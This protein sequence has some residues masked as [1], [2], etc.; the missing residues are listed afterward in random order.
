M[1]DA[2]STLTLTIPLTGPTVVYGAG[3]HGGGY[4]NLSSIKS[5]HPPGFRS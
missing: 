3:A 2:D 4:R 1:R 5:Y